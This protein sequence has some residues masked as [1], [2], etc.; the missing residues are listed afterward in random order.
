MASYDKMLLKLL[1]YSGAAS[2]LS[3]WLRGRGSVFMLHHVLPQC[4]QASDFA[5]NAGLEVTPEFLDDV[6]QLVKSK[7]YGLVSL[8]E[9]AEE[10][11]GT[12]TVKFNDGAAKAVY[13]SPPF[14]LQVVEELSVTTPA[15]LILLTVLLALLGAA[16]AIRNKSSNA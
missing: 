6:I 8:E 10:H 2:L 5:P 14:E 4:S 15:V 11:T 9:A 16:V 1:H 3:P 13:E 12:Y 7:G